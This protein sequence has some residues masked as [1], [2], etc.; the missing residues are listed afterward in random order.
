MA[1]KKPIKQVEM[2][3]EQAFLARVGMVKGVSFYQP[4]V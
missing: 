4:C 3:P 2:V 1:E